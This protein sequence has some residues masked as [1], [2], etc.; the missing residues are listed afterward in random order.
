MSFRDELLADLQNYYVHEEKKLQEG[1]KVIKAFY[2]KL[3][4]D[5]GDINKFA[6]GEVAFHIGKEEVSLTI[7]KSSLVFVLENLQIQILINNERFDTISARDNS[8]VSSKYNMPVNEELINQYLE[9][10]FREWK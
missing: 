7:R 5:M 9:A 10:A 8:C 2:T 6:K 1:L 4:Y 3:K